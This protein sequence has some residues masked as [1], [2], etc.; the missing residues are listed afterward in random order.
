MA[1]AASLAAFLIGG[2]TG[3]IAHGASAPSRSGFDV[4]TTDALQAYK[5][6]VV[7]VRH[8]VEV[9]GRRTRRT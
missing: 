3:W 4:L 8:P 1:V 9:P 6:Y 7:E 5:L 2:G